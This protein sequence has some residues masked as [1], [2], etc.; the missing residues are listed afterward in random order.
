MVQAGA[1]SETNREIVALDAD[2]RVRWLPPDRWAA[3]L[4]AIG[5]VGFALRFAGLRWGLPY[6]MH[7]DEPVILGIEF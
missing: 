2:E 6:S 1:D 4:L 7:P 3:T 5:A